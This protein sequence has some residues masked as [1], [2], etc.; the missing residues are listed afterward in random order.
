MSSICHRIIERVLLAI[1]FG[2]NL[3][4]RAAMDHETL[5]WKNWKRRPIWIRD[6]EL[7][8]RLH[9]AIGITKIVIENDDRSIYESRL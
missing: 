3:A 2:R 5:A 4:T 8:R 1:Y 7:K 9:N 6:R